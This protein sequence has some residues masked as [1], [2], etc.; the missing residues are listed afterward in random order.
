[1]FLYKK[2]SKDIVKTK[3]KTSEDKWAE[4]KQRAQIKIL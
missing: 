4:G 2:Q 1:M 3:I